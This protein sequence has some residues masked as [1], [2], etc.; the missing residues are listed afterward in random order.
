M[1]LVAIGLVLMVIQ[2]AR[3]KSNAWLLA[4][5]AISLGV[6]LYGCCFI[7]TPRL[8]ASYNVE[9]SSRSLR[10]RARSRSAIPLIRSVRR[11]LPALETYMKQIPALQT[12]IILQCRERDRLPCTAIETGGAG[13]FEHGAWSDIWLTIP[14][15]RSD[16]PNGGKG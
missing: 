4:A 8:V 14:T 16:P 3:R 11:L 6:V 13:A 9:H 15:H 1:V 12:M 7:N 5:N 10:Q 2:I